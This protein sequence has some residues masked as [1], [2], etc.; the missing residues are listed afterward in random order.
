M[1]ILIVEDTAEFRE[2]ANQSLAENHEIVFATTLEEA[3]ILLQENWDLVITDLFFPESKEENSGEIG[4]KLHE[5]LNLGQRL[6]KAMNEERRQIPLSNAYIT[7]GNKGSFEKYPPLGLHI[8][9]L[10]ISN[11]IRAIICSQG[12]RH[13]GSFSAVRWAT[14]EIIANKSKVFVERFGMVCDGCHVDKRNPQTWLNALEPR[15]DLF[16]SFEK[17]PQYLREKV[18]GI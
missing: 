17:I 10:A 9:G 7:P 16:E 15:K 14:I 4:K 1:R 2:I 6:E 18:F 3:K 13:H 11:G 8:F 5:G 12:D